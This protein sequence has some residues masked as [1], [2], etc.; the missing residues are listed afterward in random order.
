MPG[1]M[2]QHL[3]RGDLKNLLKNKFF[4]FELKKQG[5]TYKMIER[6]TGISIASKKEEFGSLELKS[7]ICYLFWS[8]IIKLRLVGKH[9]LSLRARSVKNSRLFGRNKKTYHNK[10][11]YDSNSS[12]SLFIVLFFVFFTE[13]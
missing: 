11:D 9:C 13:I 4:A 8:G 2:I 12:P 6:K 1:T 7:K 3:K 5:M 10:S